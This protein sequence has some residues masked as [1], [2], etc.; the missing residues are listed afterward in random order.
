MAVSGDSTNQAAVGGT[1]PREILSGYW[2][3]FIG[4]VCAAVL[5][6]LCGVFPWA[7]AGHD[8][9]L[10]VP[11]VVR[12]VIVIG[13][14]LVWPRLQA[15]RWQFAGVLGLILGLAMIVELWAG[16]A[17]PWEVPVGQLA[18]QWGPW[19]AVF[20]WLAAARAM[21]ERW[22]SPALHAGLAAVCAGLAMTG[23]VLAE[24]GGGVS[25][26]PWAGPWVWA[27]GRG[28]NDAPFLA[29]AGG[30]IIAGAQAP[31]IWQR[32]RR[33]PAARRRSR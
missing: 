28:A 7:R 33:F 29:L 27:V 22:S 11:A 18:G 20:V 16:S 19:L 23:Y 12:A 1:G 9:R 3:A 5:V 14:T 30:L 25:V 8:S 15:R 26:V 2:V 10:Q 32:F 6:T 31:L 24:L 13:A 17:P 21:A 4:V